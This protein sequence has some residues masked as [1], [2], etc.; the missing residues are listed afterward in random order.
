[1][2]SLWVY[3]TDVDGVV[4]ENNWPLDESEKDFEEINK[5]LPYFNEVGKARKCSRL[6]KTILYDLFLIRLK[7]W[8]RILRVTNLD[9]RILK[10]LSITRPNGTR[11]DQFLM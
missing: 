11:N 6:N 8:E 7:V 4:L 2:Q 3:N 5:A 9:F 10:L 1:M